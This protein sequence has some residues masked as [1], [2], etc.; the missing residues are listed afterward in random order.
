MQLQQYFELFLFDLYK[1]F[2]ISLSFHLSRDADQID[3]SQL[4][5]DS[6][7]RSYELQMSHQI[8]HQL[9]ST[10]RF[11]NRIARK[12]A[13]SQQYSV[14]ILRCIQSRNK[15]WRNR[16]RNKGTFSKKKRYLAELTTPRYHFSKILK[17]LCPLPSDN[18]VHIPQFDISAFL[19]FLRLVEWRPNILSTTQ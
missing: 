9:S 5:D 7:D 14:A 18:I 16:K 4:L 13:I 6:P 1:C 12:Y 3:S 15:F 10:F 19:I 11:C 2:A 17:P 8:R